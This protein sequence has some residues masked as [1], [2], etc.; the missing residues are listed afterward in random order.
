[1]VAGNDVGGGRVG[2]AGRPG[3]PRRQDDSGIREGALFVNRRTGPGIRRDRVDH[4]PRIG[5]DRLADSAVAVADGEME[6]E[7]DVAPHGPFHAIVTDVTAGNPV[8]RR[9]AGRFA[10]GRRAHAQG[11]RIPPGGIDRKVLPHSGG[12]I[13]PPGRSS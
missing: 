12:P 8:H 13:L 10:H 4:C 1:M 11:R 7:N 9:R 3:R 5:H 6:R 2:R